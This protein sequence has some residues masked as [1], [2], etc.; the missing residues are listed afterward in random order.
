MCDNE[1]LRHEFNV[2]VAD[3]D[4]SIVVNSAKYP[5]SVASAPYLHTHPYYEL[6]TST[7]TPFHIGLRGR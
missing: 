5:V 4:L 7:D 1:D 3:I 2:R 6:V